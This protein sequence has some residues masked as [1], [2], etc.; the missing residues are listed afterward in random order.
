LNAEWA[1]RHP[2]A[3]IPEEARAK[4]IFLLCRTFANSKLSKNVLPVPQ[5]H[6][7]NIFLQ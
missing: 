6:Q 1:V 3:A 4:A 5:E 7:K 2:I